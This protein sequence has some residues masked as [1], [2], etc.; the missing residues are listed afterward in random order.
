M[1]VKKDKIKKIALIAAIVILPGGMVLGAVHL[2]RKMR[3]AS[4]SKNK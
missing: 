4:K 1:N 2:I 3:D